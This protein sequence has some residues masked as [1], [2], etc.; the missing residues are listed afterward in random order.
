MGISELRQAGPSLAFERAGRNALENDLVLRGGL[1]PDALAHARI[2]QA[3]CDTSIDRI[4][5]AEN[6]M[7][8]DDILAAQARLYRSR[9]LSRADVAKLEPAAVPCAPQLLVKHVIL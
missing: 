9:P 3:H 8:P 4:L 7:D 6:L 5:L 1:D 2:V